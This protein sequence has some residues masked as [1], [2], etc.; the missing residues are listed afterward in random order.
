MA[1]AARVIEVLNQLAR[2]NP[3]FVGPKVDF[4]GLAGGE[5][6]FH[7]VDECR[8]GAFVGIGRDQCVQLGPGGE[9]E[10]AD[11]GESGAGSGLGRRAEFGQALGAG[12][13]DFFFIQSGY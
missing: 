10:K 12:E 13:N 4:E 3:Q 11:G 9:A 7:G 6:G 1:I 2:D 5:G 8:Q